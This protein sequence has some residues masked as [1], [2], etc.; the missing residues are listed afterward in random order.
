MAADMFGRQ[1]ATPG[2]VFGQP[3]QQGGVFS[4]GGRPLETPEEMQRLAGIGIGAQR[5]AEEERRAYEQQIGALRA[6]QAEQEARFAAARA[7]QMEALGVLGQRAQTLEGGPALLQAQQ[8]RESAQAQAMRAPQAILGGQL[9]AAAAQGMGAIEQ[10]AAARQAAY[11]RGLA[12]MGAGTLE[13][14]QA[15]RATEAELLRDMQ[16]RFLAA[17]RIAAQG[18]QRAAANKAATLGGF[19][20]VAG[21]ILGAMVGGPAG[22]AVGGKLGGSAG[23]MA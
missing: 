1:Q 6:M 7:P 22:A 23:G 3:S 18:E 15:R 8:A 21:T 13:E 16:T 5:N 4:P 14:A 20:T 11:A 9:G 12:Q 17:Q 2:G 19:G 10:E